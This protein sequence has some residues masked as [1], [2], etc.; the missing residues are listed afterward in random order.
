MEVPAWGHRSANLPREAG[1]NQDARAADAKKHLL[2][3]SPAHLEGLG[4]IGIQVEVVADH[5]PGPMALPVQDSIADCIS[6]TD[7]YQR[8]FL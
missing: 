3:H 8:I 2:L 5:A 7:R 4:Q 6:H 1:N